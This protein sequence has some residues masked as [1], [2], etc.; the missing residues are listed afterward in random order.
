MSG[1]NLQVTEL[2]LQSE[3]W[4]CMQGMPGE[5]PLLSTNNGLCVNMQ[6]KSRPVEKNKIK[7]ATCWSS[8]LGCMFG[9]EQRQ[10]PGEDHTSSEMLWFEA[11]SVP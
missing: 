11:P 9:T 8:E 4:T 3:N 6:T 5:E 2:L 7:C 10:P 1:R